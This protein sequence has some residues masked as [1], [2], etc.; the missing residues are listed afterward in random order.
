MKIQINEKNAGR[1][2][3]EIKAVEG[4]STVR[5]L[6]VQDIMDSCVYVEKELGIPK[7]AM[8]GI[9]I[10]VDVNAQDFPGAYKW[11]PESTQ[12]RAQRGK[13]GWYLIKISRERTRR[14]SQMHYV[15]LTDAAKE[16]IINSKRQ[17]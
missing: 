9:V 10:D 5:L 2:T 7:K 11:T 1:I 15:S 4:R 6:T 8:D 14:R 12:F 3:E 13:G 16:A 17:F